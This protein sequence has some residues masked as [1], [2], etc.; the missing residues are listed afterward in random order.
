MEQVDRQDSQAIAEL[1]VCLDIAAQVV[2]A[3]LQD[4][5]VIAAY[6]EC[7]EPAVRVGSA[8]TVV[9]AEH[10]VRQDQVVFLDLA[11]TAVRQDRVALAE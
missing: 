4:S 3:G 10:R 7:Q 6:Q 5:A 8:V 2:Q 1:V 11:A 9:Q